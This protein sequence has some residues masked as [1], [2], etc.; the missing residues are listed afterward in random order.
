MITIFILTGPSGVGKTTSQY[1]F[2]ESGYYVIENNF[3]V[4]M[5]STLNY[6]YSNPGKQD[7][8]LFIT[9]PQYAMET[10]NIAKKW[11]QDKKDILLRLLTLTCDAK[12]LVK[13]FKLTR[14]VHP[15]TAIYKI[16][17][18]Q[19]I[20]SDLEAIDSLSGVADYRIDTSDMQAIDLRK[21]L[22][23]IVTSRVSNMVSVCFM[24]FG[25][26]YSIPLDVD[27]VFDTRAL[28]NPY[29]VENLRQYSGL[30]KPVIDYLESFPVTEQTFSAMVSYLDFYLEQVQKDGRGNYT[31]GICCSGGRHRSVYFA[32]RLAK[33]YQ[34]KY[35]VA[36]IH[37][38]IKKDLN[39]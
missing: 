25:H 26:K 14:H 28:P 4:A 7:K 15:M 16:S 35:K 13:R 24:S 29:W 3:P 39:Q 21:Y 8:F 19:A 32:E 27:L 36:T 10:Y 30:D 23:S 2:E 5:E 31:I 6:L 18:T 17:L 11:A 12:T 33:H 9:L 20:K 38:D 22:F 1:V 37:R 34:E